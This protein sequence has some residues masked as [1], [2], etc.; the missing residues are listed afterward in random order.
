MS[1]VVARLSSAEERLVAEALQE[2]SSR[3]DARP[4]FAPPWVV[5]GH[6]PPPLVPGPAPSALFP[7]PWL[8]LPPVP[9]YWETAAP[10]P[11]VLFY[12]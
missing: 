7:G 6:L 3:G 12:Q 5:S 1:S 9:F 8:L 4:F 11:S 10:S 2:L